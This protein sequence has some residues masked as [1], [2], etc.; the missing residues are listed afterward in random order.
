MIEILT[1][2]DVLD[3]YRAHGH[4][5]YGECVSELE[6]ALQCATIA[7]QLCMP[8]EVTAAALLHDFGHLC[9]AG[10]SYHGEPDHDAHHEV[11]GADALL[12][13]FTP[14]VIGAVRLHVAAKRYLCRRMPGYVEQLST[15]SLRS[16]ELQG[17]AMSEE[18]C[19][20]FEYMPHA[21]LAVRLRRI[22]DDA[23]VPGTPTPDLDHFRPVLER[24][25]R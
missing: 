7:E 9:R 4:L 14:A 24:V 23:K 12:G 25:R 18:E 3:V 15:A 5:A 22:D 11:L 6:H 20:R 13:L 10:E 21:E 8:D 16:L 1:V 17:G 2:D 19:R